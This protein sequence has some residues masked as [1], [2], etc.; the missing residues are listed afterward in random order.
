MRWKSSLGAVMLF[1]AAPAFAQTETVDPATIE[2]PALTAPAASD[3][4][5][6]HKYFPGVLAYDEDRVI[7]VKAQVSGVAPRP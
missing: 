1:G 7:D 5:S 2:I 3:S 6:F 4:G